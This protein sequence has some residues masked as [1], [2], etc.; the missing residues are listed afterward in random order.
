MRNPL[1]SPAGTKTNTSCLDFD[2]MT[3]TQDYVVDV[4]PQSDA[5]SGGRG[6]GYAKG[7]QWH[8]NGISPPV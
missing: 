8:V 4:D 6:V 2:C 1:H 5:V 3:A 7:S